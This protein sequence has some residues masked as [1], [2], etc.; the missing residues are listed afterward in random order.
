VRRGPNDPRVYRPSGRWTVFLWLLGSIIAAGGALGTW[1]FATGHDVGNPRAVPIL[2]IV[3][4]AILGLGAYLVLSIVRSKVVLHGDQIEVHEVV[5]KYA[6]RRDEILGW[7]MSQPSPPYIVFVPRDHNR[8]QVKVAP[9]FKVDE[10]FSQ[11][12][13]SLPNLDVEDAKASEKE[14][15]ASL[16]IGATPEGRI[17]ALARAKRLARILNVVALVT[18][19]WGLFYP[20]PYGVLVTV[21]IFLPWLAIGIVG[22]SKG[23]FRLDRYRNDVHPNLASSFIFPG[24]I[25]TLRVLGDFNVLQ[26]AQAVWLAVGLGI[27]LSFAACMVDSALRAK[28]WTPVVLLFITVAYGFGAGLE[29]NALL[30]R[31][32]AIRYPAKITGKHI[33]RGRRTVY[34]L[35]LEPWGPRREAN[36]L[37]VARSF[38][39][40][41]QPGESVCL[42]LRQG[43]FSIPW[44]M[45]VTCR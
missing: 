22:R 30:D 34:Y 28:R 12:M 6:L 38:Y 11:W 45:Q 10:A 32:P 23:L 44:Y 7:R 41:A 37:A 35:H 8:R 40:A 29:A 4:I 15:A 17:D 20:R 9:I 43:A 25:L 14:I 31:S 39:Q 19:A 3:C 27:L 1:Y 33:S 16:E 18:L 21:L 42:R 5:R 24:F 26:W 2:T 13:D 36:N